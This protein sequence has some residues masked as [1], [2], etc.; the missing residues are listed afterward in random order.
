MFDVLATPSAVKDGSETISETGDGVEIYMNDVHFHY[1]GVRTKPI[2]R[3]VTLHARPGQSIGIVGPS[4]SGKSTLLK[5]LLREYDPSGGEILVEGKKI[6]SLKSES[7]RKIA[8]VVPQD[9]ML[10]NDTL[11]YN[12]AYGRPE[13]SVEEIKD[14]IRAAQ[15]DT[16]F[17]SRSQ[18]LNT[19]VGDRGRS[20]SG[21]EK[22]R[23][24]IARAFLRSP[25]LLLCDEATSA[26]DS[27]T[28]QS[29]LASLKN[30]SKGRTSFFVAHRLSTIR[31]C[32]LIIVMDEGKIVEQ[33]THTELLDLR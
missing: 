29:I 9:T 4:G 19:A 1:P 31:H 30:I 3:G 6:E 20:L 2:L 23:V 32:D 12:I 15:L 22:Q 11:K 18:G 33:G 8:A 14:A 5:L 26:L 27:A 13:A 24:A 7:L 25:R 17:N 28:E 21:G 10:F 16:I